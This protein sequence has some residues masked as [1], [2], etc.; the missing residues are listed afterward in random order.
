V[1]PRA[2]EHQERDAPA[3]L[4]DIA[5]LTARAA[6]IGR[7]HAAVVAAHDDDRLGAERGRPLD[8]PLE[9]PRV[10]R[11]AR[12]GNRHDE[13]EAQSN[14][15]AH[16]RAP[17]AAH[18]GKAHATAEIR[19]NARKSRALAAPAGRLVVPFLGVLLPTS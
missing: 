4:Q 6:D 3:G 14:E 12:R 5:A 1:R 11:R 2:L 7:V 13:R 8:R 16:H 18:L 19:D 15:Q 17:P 10:T 9:E